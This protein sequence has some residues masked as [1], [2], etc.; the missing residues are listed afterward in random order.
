MAHGTFHEAMPMSWEFQTREP[1]ELVWQ[2]PSPTAL[3]VQRLLS[4][5]RLALAAVWRDLQ[6]SFDM[7]VVSSVLSVFP[8]GPM[9]WLIEPQ[10]ET[11]AANPAPAFVF[12]MKIDWTVLLNVIT[13]DTWIKLTLVKWEE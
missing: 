6:F 10:P 3:S 9:S 1:P 7:V 8:V 5:M 2:N 12:P 13:T 4:V 11:F